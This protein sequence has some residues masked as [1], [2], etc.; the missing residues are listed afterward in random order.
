MLVENRCVE[1]GAPFYTRM[2]RQWNDDGTVT[3]LFS[4][5]TRVCHVEAGEICGI[6]D[7]ISDRIGFPIERIVVE[8]DRKASRRITDEVLE[9]GH[10]LV[11]LFGKSWA[12]SP[13]SL[14]VT[15]DVGSSDKNA[16]TPSGE[17]DPA[18]PCKPCIRRLT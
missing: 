8:G 13:V 11:G 2:F 14:K 1:C 17:L 4:R 3:G 10:S 6:L 9:T 15:L 16:E 18:A 7:G 12:G 5:E